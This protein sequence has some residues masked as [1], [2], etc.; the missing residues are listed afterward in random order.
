MAPVSRKL[1]SEFEPYVRVGS[2]VDE[3]GN[4]RLQDVEEVRMERFLW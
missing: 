2:L 1:F 3:V 4:L